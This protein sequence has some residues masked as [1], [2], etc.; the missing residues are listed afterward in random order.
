MI[1]IYTDG[2]A[3]PNPGPG[4][5]G[6]VISGLAQRE[7][8]LELFQGFTWTTNNRMELLGVIVGLENTP[9]GSDITVFSDSRYIVD[10]MNR[11][12]VKKWQANA[13]MRSKN[14]PAVSPD[15][16]ER[17]LGLVAG[18]NVQFSWVKGHAGIPG[19]ERADALATQALQ[20]RDLLPDPG[21]DRQ[22]EP[23]NGP[24]RS[25]LATWKQT[26]KGRHWRSYKSHN[27]TLTRSSNNNSRDWHGIIYNNGKCVQ[28]WTNYGANLQDAMSA[29][30]GAVDKILP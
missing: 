26:R 5:Y 27:I 2:A 6:A 15:L 1:T 29:M 18:R 24:A 19:N 13:W 12:W 22:G 30:E 7:Q 4:G 25:R 20:S 23:E 10:A 21:Y 11:G 14:Q 17:M 16:W 28:G 3:S 8:P 9:E